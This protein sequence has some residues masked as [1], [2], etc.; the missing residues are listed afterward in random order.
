VLWNNLLVHFKEKGVL[1]EGSLKNLKQS[2]L[3]LNRPRKFYPE[4]RFSPVVA[5]PYEGA[6]TE[7]S[8]VSPA[9]TGG[10]PDAASLQAGVTVSTRAY[11]PPP[12]A[13]GAAAPP[14]PYAFGGPVSSQSLSQPLSQ[15][16]S[17]V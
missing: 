5:G 6:P 7:G 4:R 16:R 2:M 9:H 17:Q 3:R 11:H 12:F 10:D 8:G 15:A 13:P 1:V 14:D